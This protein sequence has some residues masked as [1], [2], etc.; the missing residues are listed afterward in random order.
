MKRI[1][2]LLAFVVMSK[3]AFGQKELVTFNEH[4]KYIF[5]QVTEMPGISADTLYNRCLPGLKKIGPAALEGPILVAGKTIDLEAMM[6]MY[7]STGPV[8]HEEGELS[9][10]LHIE[11]KDN[12]YRFWLTDF[13]FTP[14]QRNRYGVYERSHQ[15]AKVLEEVKT[16]YNARMFD[17]YLEQIAK[18]GNQFGADLKKLVANSAKTLAQPAKTDTRKW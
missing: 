8:K 12:K 7:S 13:V 9:Y 14:Y 5:Y 6:M 1:I 16:R 2:T 15:Q 18:Y 10:A 11:F 17:V 3:I 4:N